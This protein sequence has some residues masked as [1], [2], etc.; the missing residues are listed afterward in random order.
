MLILT[1]TNMLGGQVTHTCFA[2]DGAVVN[3][4]AKVSK[5]TTKLG[6]FS[7]VCVAQ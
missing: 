7:L 4:P 6:S 1:V 3:H 2:T 5:R